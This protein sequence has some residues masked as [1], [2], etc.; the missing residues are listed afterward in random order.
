MGNNQSREV[1]EFKN[2]YVKHG[3]VDDSRYGHVTFYH[4]KYNPQEVVMVKD[5]W[6]NSIAESQEIAGFIENRKDISHPNLAENKHYLKT[7]DKQW[8]S[9]FHK[10]TTAFEFQE[11]NLE[12]QIRDRNNFNGGDFNQY[13]KYS[14]PQLWYMANSVVNVDTA[15]ARDGGS[16]HG[17]IQPSTVLLDPENRVK[18]IDNGMIHADKPSYNRMLYNRKNKVALSPLLCEQMEQTKVKPEYEP[19][20][21]DSWG[22][23]MTL[24]CASTNTSLD[25]YY[26]W[27]KPEIKRH[28]VNDSLDQI[29]GPYSK[30]F[31]GFVTSCL[32]ESQDMRPSMEDHQSFLRPYQRE[33]ESVQLD[34]KK[35]TNAVN[36]PA[37]VNPA[38]I[39]GPD[40]TDV[41]GG[42]DFFDRDVLPVNNFDFGGVIATDAG[43]F[44]DKKEEV[45]IDDKGNFFADNLF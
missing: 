5:K 32:E 10:H 41:I 11:N 24:L 3:E 15:L 12:K 45:L 9:T 25:D 17:D 14:E 43:N 36:N 4:S 30:Q 8:C 20:K 13:D 39:R 7:E 27:K 2:Q 35:K 18:I 44:F 28:M 38:I 1:E 21:E 34:F 26:D 6:T 40:F 37:P 33:A 42:G 23:G 19:S 29:N 22:L 16:Y 31:H